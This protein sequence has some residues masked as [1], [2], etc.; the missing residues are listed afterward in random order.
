M[1]KFLPS[2][3]VSPLYEGYSDGACKGNPGNG[4]WGAMCEVEAKPGHFLRFSD[5]GGKKATTNQEMELTG[6]AKLLSI[7]PTGDAKRIKLFLDSEYVLKG[8]VKGGTGIISSE[9]GLTGWVNNWEKNGWMTSEKKDVKHKGLWKEIMEGCKSHMKDGS[10]IEFEWVKGHDGNEG[11][12]FVD[13]L[14]NEGVK[15]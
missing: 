15:K 11:N 5:F 7:I 10:T 12:E 4:G 2:K 14:A 13:M 3:N 8:I 1:K 9:T 6:C